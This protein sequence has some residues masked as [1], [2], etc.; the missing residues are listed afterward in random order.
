M[1][2]LGNRLLVEQTYTKVQ[3]KI[4][5]IASSK[6]SGSSDDFTVDQRIIQL[7][8]EYSKGEL[9]IGDIPIIAE[10]ALQGGRRQISKS[11]TQMV[12]HLIVEA[13]DIIGIDDEP[14][15]VPVPMVVDTKPSLIV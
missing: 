13:D 5:K 12:W 10:H 3:S 8:T 9:S 15:V 14:V 7:G 2:V 4:I 1:K 11:E 6:G